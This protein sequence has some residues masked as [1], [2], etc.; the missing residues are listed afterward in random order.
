MWTRGFACCSNVC[1]ML[2]H[3]F[4]LR[5]ACMLPLELVTFPVRA[6]RETLHTL[7]RTSGSVTM[8]VALEKMRTGDYDALI[9]DTPL[10]DYAAV[11]ECYM[12]SVGKWYTYKSFQIVSAN[13]AG[14][15]L[16]SWTFNV[17]IL[18]AHI[19]PKQ[20]CLLVCEW[21]CQSV[22]TACL[23]QDVILEVP[24]TLC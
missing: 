9:I 6:W 12:V 20:L 21:P 22:T 17:S 2:S 1:K 13:H 10:A 24:G 4:M 16:F 23:L 15:D 5:K 3:I 11:S 14:T 7:C 8:P 18:W 19:R